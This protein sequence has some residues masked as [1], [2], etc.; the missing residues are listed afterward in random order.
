MKK[1]T[2]I[3]SAVVLT[4][5][6]GCVNSDSYGTPDLSADCSNLTKTKEVVDITSVSTSAYAEYTDNDIIEAYVTSSD[7]GGNFYKSISFVSVDGQQGFSMPIDDYNLYTKFPPGSKVFVKL[8]DRYYVK[9]YGSTVIGS[10]YNNETPDDPTDDA[11]GR[12]SIV[13]YKNVLNK[14]CLSVNEDQLVNHVTVAQAKSDAYLNKLIEFD[15]AEFTEAS[16]GKTFFDESLNNLGSATNHMIRDL[17]GDEVILRASKYAV[18]ASE[19]VPT[20]SGRIRGVMTKYNNDYQ[21]MIRTLNDVDLP[22]PRFK[23]LLNES[24]SS[25]TSF[26]TWTAFSVTGAQVWT[27]SPTFGNPGGMAKMTG[28]ATSNFA[29]EDW[30][31][32]PEQDLSSLTGAKLTFDNAYKFAG[33]PIQVYISNNYSGSGS[34]NASGVTWTQLTG[35][36]LSSGNYVYVSSGDID[37]SAFTGPG[38]QKVFVA[39]KYTSTTSAA[40]TWE[41]DN[42][43][44]S[45]N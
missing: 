44:I 12:I 40:S 16:L 41:I 15:V 10:L 32:S 30:L 34:P 5:L 22:N 26:S 9:Q 13:A 19:S 3:L 28:F 21:F 35:F 17:N 18:F 23:P 2:I 1:I 37:I 45:A 6:G 24:F 14:S 25:L 27:Y 39:F 11:V 38:N 4:T 29:N 8:K 36:A 42:V 20:G 43:K 7:E 31:I 33:N